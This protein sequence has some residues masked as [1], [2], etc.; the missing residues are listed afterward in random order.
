M[1]AP[2]DY[3]GAPRTIYCFARHEPCCERCRE[4]NMNEDVFNMSLRKFL[5]KVGISG[6]RSIEITVRDSVS[7]GRLKGNEKLSVKVTLTLSQT[8]LDAVI[9][10]E[11]ELE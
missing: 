7:K 4:E 5:K 11:I 3:S 2:I 8:D 6:Q 9:D 1:A 10:G